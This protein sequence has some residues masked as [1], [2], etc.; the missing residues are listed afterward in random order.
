[1]KT[2]TKEQIPL[3]KDCAAVCKIRGFDDECTCGY[4]KKIGED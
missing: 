2:P 1:M 3:C 4:Y